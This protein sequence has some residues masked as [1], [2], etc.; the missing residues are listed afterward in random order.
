LTS[1][2]VLSVN[3]GRIVAADWAGRLRRTA[4]DK[5]RVAGRLDVDEAGVEGDE[6]ADT[7]YHGGRDKAVYV[8]AREDL[9]G[10]EHV[11]GRRLHNGQFGENLTTCGIDV[12]Q[13]LIGER[14]RIGSALLEVCS[15]RLPCRVF[16]A[17]LAERGWVRRFTEEGRP[18]PYLRVLE[19]GRVGS[20]DPVEV[21][22]RPD[23]GLTVTTVFRALTTRPD[24]LPPLLQVPTLEHDLVRRA[25]TLLAAQPTVG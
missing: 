20:G 3:V 8:F 24:L 21:V 16:A 14:W 19:P 2:H 6:Q 15:V 13:A 1:A 12:N 7:R 11:L 22:H 17:W 4:I 9:D 18:G 25:G 23:H 10:W 5:V